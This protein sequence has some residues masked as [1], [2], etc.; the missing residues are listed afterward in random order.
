MLTSS[1]AGRAMELV[2]E[3]LADA[4]QY[5]GAHLYYPAVVGYIRAT[6][7]DDGLSDSEARTEVGLALT[8][9]DQFYAERE[10]RSVERQLAGEVPGEV[11]EREEP[12]ADGR[13]LPDGVVG[14][15]PASRVPG[16]GPR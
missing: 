11:Y 13:P 6:V 9:L 8:A 1:W 4:A 7:A 5:P 3:M 16:D 2:D 12:D 14:F 15:V 10:R